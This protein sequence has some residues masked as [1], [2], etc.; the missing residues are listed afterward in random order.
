MLSIC[1]LPRWMDGTRSVFQSAAVEALIDSVL[2]LPFFN[3][4]VIKC[5]CWCQNSEVDKPRV[6]FPNTIVAN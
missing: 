4:V 6:R 1:C 2:L 3:G 5:Y